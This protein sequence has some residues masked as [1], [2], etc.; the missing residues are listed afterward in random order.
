MLRL[1]CWR[2]RRDI[3]LYSDGLLGAA[4]ADRVERHV[5]RCPACYDRLLEAMA[6]S[7]VLRDLLAVAGP[8][9]VGARAEDRRALGPSRPPKA[10][11]HRPAVLVLAAALLLALA[12]HLCQRPDCPRTPKAACCCSSQCACPARHHRRH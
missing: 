12:L 7:L 3:V 11:P 5:A 10:G 6:E 9:L 8:S 2:L 1:A 4:D